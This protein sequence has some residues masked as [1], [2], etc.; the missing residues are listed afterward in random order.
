MP[1]R[2]HCEGTFFATE[3][4]SNTAGRWLHFVRHDRYR[5][6]D[7]FVVLLLMTQFEQHF[8][9][10]PAR[11]HCEG[12]FFA[13]EAISNPAGRWLHFVRNDRY[14]SGDGFVELL[15]MTY[16]E[17]H[18]VKIPARRH[19]EGALFATEAISNPAGR[20][21]HF[22]RHDRY[23]SGDGFTSFAMTGIGR[24][25]ASLYYNS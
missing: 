14:R 22:V 6:G 23:R 10:M 25:M 3:A 4:I 11:R 17:Q 19:C 16:F 9:K 5:S 20:W 18:F 12:A 24:E 2:R 13:T 7:G 21:L 1:A 15:F 8:V